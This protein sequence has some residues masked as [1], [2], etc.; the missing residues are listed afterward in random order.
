MKNLIQSLILIVGFSCAAHTVNADGDSGAAV[1]E[2]L[3]ANLLDAMKNATE[4]GFAGRLER[5]SPVVAES[6]DF[7][8][9]ARIVTGK[10]WKSIDAEQRQ[11]F[12]EIFVDLSA[13]TYAANFDGYSGEK[14]ATLETEERGDK[15]LVKT[16]IEKSDGEQITLD[17]L[18]RQV[19]ET[20]RIVNVVADGVSDL[21]LKRAEYTAVI[22]NEGFD[23]LMAKLSDK[24]DNYRSTER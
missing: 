15:Q 23:S 4:W 19:D 17:Y 13:S 2:K 8:T 11:R 10:H 14:F 16:V 3:H 6:F 21:S 18:L 20:W 22:K 5:L 24:I 9:I 12:I 7:D 1:V